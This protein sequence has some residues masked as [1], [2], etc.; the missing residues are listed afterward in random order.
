MAKEDQDELQGL[1]EAIDALDDELVKLLNHRA[2]LSV[3]VRRTLGNSK[4]EVFVPE[5]EAQVLTRVQIQNAGPLTP[6]HLAAIYREVLSASRDLQR[7]T[8]VAYLGPRATFT[9]QAALGR[10]G[11]SAEYVAAASIP[12]IYNEV[13]RGAADF[14]VM[15]VENSTEGPVFE[16]L[17]LLNDGE[18]RICAE[19]TI[20]VAHYLLARGPKE[21][22]R[23]VYSHPQAA[24]Q[25]RRWLAQNLPGCE[26]LHVTSTARA[27]E[28]AAEEAAA[29]AIATRLAAEVYDLKILEQNIQDY[30]SNYTRFF[31]VGQRMTERPSGR[32]KTAIVFSIR[33]RVGALKDMLEV[34]ARASL[35]LTSIQSRPSRRRAWDYL[36][37]VEFAGHAGD[38]EV[39]AVLKDAEQH[40]VFLKVLGAW[41]VPTE[42]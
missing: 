7:H 31:V 22:V 40:C 27:A 21:A 11:S 39:K 1:R 36:F 19:I 20:P 32:D 2:A 16:T 10:F 14:G 3:E 25:C 38:P 29:A 34:F 33:D 42:A 28:Q 23:R 13:V 18:L 8:R 15:P 12:D 26:V 35:N 41:P 6:E 37:F 4:P 17:D 9:H 30:S 24:A 5:R